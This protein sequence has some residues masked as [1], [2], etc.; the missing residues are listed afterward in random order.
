MPTIIKAASSAGG[1]EINPAVADGAIVIQSSAA[2]GTN[3]VNAV[4]AAADGT[5][6]FLRAPLVTAVQSMV[7]LH[8]A[9]GYGSTNTMIRRLTTVVTN[10][11]TDITYTDSATLGA[12]FTIN[13]NGVYAISYVENFGSLSYLGV[14]LNSAQLTTVVS[15]V[16]AADR[17][18]LAIVPTANT[19]ALVATTLYLSSGG[20]VR[21]HT[22][23]AAAG[24]DP[25]FVTFIITR[26]A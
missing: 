3:V 2:N 21:P 16:N 23:G 6:T 1:W 14:S 10:Q 26:V 20:V 4:V 15:S 11:G 24:L 25:N 18:A 5:L 19:A 22:N 9:N 12:S 7:R 13:T 17:L 8:T